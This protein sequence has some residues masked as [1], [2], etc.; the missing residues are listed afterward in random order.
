[1][2]NKFHLG[3]LDENKNEKNT[4]NNN[5]QHNWRD[6]NNER[7]DRYSNHNRGYNNQYNSNY[8]RDRKDGYNKNY[9]HQNHYRDYRSYEKDYHHNNRREDFHSFDDNRYKKEYQAGNNN[10]KQHEATDQRRENGERKIKIEKQNEED[11]NDNRKKD[12]RSREKEEKQDSSEKNTKSTEKIMEKEGL[13]K[14]ISIKIEKVSD[15]HSYLMDPSQISQSD[16]NSHFNNNDITNGF[17]RGH[18]NNIIVL[19]KLINPQ[20]NNNFSHQLEHNIP[21]VKFSNNNS[22]MINRSVPFLNND[23]TQRSVTTKDKNTR[24]F[25]IANKNKLKETSNRPTHSSAPIIIKKEDASVST[26]KKSSQVIENPKKIL[27]R[28]YN[29]NSPSSNSASAPIIEKSYFPLIPSGEELQKLKEESLVEQEQILKKKNEEKEEKTRLKL[30][31][32]REVEEQEKQK[33]LIKKQ[34]QLQINMEF[35]KKQEEI[36]QQIQIQLREKE[37][38]ERLQNERKQREEQEKDL[39]IQKEKE[40]QLQIK[41]SLLERERLL[42]DQREESSRQ[43]LLLKQQQEAGNNQPF[44]QINGEASSVVREKLLR[45]QELK[46][47]QELEFQKKMQMQLERQQKEQETLEEIK[48]KQKEQEKQ[49]KQKQQIEIE[50]KQ[51]LLE[52]KKKDLIKKKQ[53]LHQ[54]KSFG[55]IPNLAKSNNQLS[56]EKPKPKRL[57]LSPEL[58]FPGEKTSPSVLVK[59]SDQLQRKTISKSKEKKRPLN[60]N[61]SV[62]NRS[63]KK[64]K[65]TPN[66]HQSTKEGTEKSG[67]KRN[68]NSSSDSSKETNNQ[69]RK[70]SFSEKISKISP[71]NEPITDNSRRHSSNSS[72]NT[73]LESTNETDVKKKR[74]MT[75]SLTSKQIKE[76]ELK[77]FY[78]VKLEKEFPNVSETLFNNHNFFEA[79]KSFK[80]LPLAIFGG[81]E[82][83]LINGGAS[84]KFD[85]TKIS[86]EKFINYIHE[87][88]LKGSRI[89]RDHLT[90]V[91]F[92]FKDELKIMNGK[93]V[94]LYSDKLQNKKDL[95]NLASRTDPNNNSPSSLKFETQIESPSIE[96][97]L[98]SQNLILPLK[99]E[100]SKPLIKPSF[101][102]L[103][104]KSRDFW[105]K[106]FGHNIIVPWEEFSQKL[107][108]NFSDLV[109]EDYENCQ[110]IVNN[111]KSKFIL[112]GFETINPRNFLK[113]LNGLN[114]VQFVEFEYKSYF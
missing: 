69:L 77:G 81:F 42:N 105:L 71:S 102:I 29:A 46:N 61:E 109:G 41:N 113:A 4:K 7:Y 26:D 53:E 50:K 56:I 8:H 99:K 100:D 48:K 23:R 22:P 107:A 91:Y 38:L 84:V 54:R 87:Q 24:S 3:N 51:Q 16:L 95:D 45:H 55:S 92:V 21:I 88:C 1:M 85:D 111:M 101:E 75:S 74:I 6:N 103:E 73:S 11:K 110:F 68:R 10:S 31:L 96:K 33:E 63:D 86:I 5:N 27:L 104:E 47:K 80:K 114:F 94:I 40:I 14:S 62:D 52:L 37:T 60:S 30:Q 72:S 82:G 49:K 32:Q 18:P 93:N 25:E 2:I 106:S 15:D 57:S 64:P 20:A 36:D 66:N 112:S 58:H 19:K 89:Y 34:K 67:E 9:D 35:K 12:S 44:N 79:L 90:D 59:G 17:Y 43:Q 13:N 97:N 83:E 70:L 28:Q 108:Q 39:Q 76:F 78:H 98:G 65:T